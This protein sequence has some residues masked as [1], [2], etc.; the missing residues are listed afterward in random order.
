M[1]QAQRILTAAFFAALIPALILSARQR[2]HRMAAQQQPYGRYTRQQVIDR[3][4]PILAAVLPESRELAVSANPIQLPNSGGQTLLCWDVESSD[5][6]GSAPV[7]ILFDA[8]SGQVCRL[9]RELPDNSCVVP[10]S[11]DQVIPSGRRWLSVLGY[12]ADW[13]C[14]KP[15]Q[16]MGA[17]WNITLCTPEYHASLKMIERTGTLIYAAI[18]PTHQQNSR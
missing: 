1:S 16:L 12:R 18:K 10:V 15:P 9:G 5:A 7:H 17:I 11:R 2:Q 8:V 6:R 4:R 13:Q 3:A 14:V